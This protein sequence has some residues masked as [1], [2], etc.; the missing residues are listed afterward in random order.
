MGSAAWPGPVGTFTEQEIRDF[1]Q[2][3]AVS[4]RDQLISD[5]IDAS[6]FVIDTVLPPQQRQ[7]SEDEDVQAEDRF[8]QLTLLESGR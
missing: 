3:R 5:G 7:N 8:V 6:R 4:V 2:A 1:A